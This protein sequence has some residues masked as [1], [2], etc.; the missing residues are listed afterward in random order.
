M[1]CEKQMIINRFHPRL[2][3]DI[4]NIIKSFSFYDIETAAKLEAKRANIKKMHNARM[5][6]IC[7]KFQHHTISRRH[8]YAFYKEEEDDGEKWI[9]LNHNIRNICVQMQGDNCR[10]CGNYKR[11][12]ETD[13]ALL[14]ASIKCYCSNA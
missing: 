14:P 8:P 3:V 1:S 10:K 2:P 11:T 5:K 9:L 13:F 12:Y 7:F 6:R 4:L